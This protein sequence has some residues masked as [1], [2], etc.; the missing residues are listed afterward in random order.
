MTLAKNEHFFANLQQ[1]DLKEEH[2]KM[3]A[4]GAN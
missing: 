3:S 1:L 4:P 2:G